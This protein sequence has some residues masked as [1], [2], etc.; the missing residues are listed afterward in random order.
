M[1]KVVLDACFVSFR[2]TRN[3][4]RWGLSGC[5]LLLLLVGVAHNILIE[6]FVQ[7]LAASVLQLALEGVECCELSSCHLSSTK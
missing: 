4:L 5:N 3:H 6:H 7:K 1:F 2:V